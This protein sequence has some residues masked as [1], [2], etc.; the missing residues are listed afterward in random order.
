MTP[1]TLPEIITDLPAAIYHADRDTISKHGLDKIAEAPAKY[2]YLLDNP[3]DPTPAMRWGTLVHL[4]VLE[5]DRFAEE[6]VV[7]PA[8]APERPAARSLNAKKPRP[9]V[10]E[11][12]EW[13]SRFDQE[14]AEKQIVSAVEIEEI[15]AI[16]NAV[17]AHP[18]ARK[19]ITAARSV[20][21]A[22]IYWEA[23]N[24]IKCRCRPDLL[25][26][27]GIA[28]DLK[29]TEDASPRAFAKSVANFRY[30]VQ[31]AFYLDGLAAVAGPSE[32]KGFAFVCVEKK[33]PYLV[34][35]YEASPEMIAAGRRLYERDLETFAECLRTDTWPGYSEKVERLDL[36]AWA[37][38]I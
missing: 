17:H 14:N 10:L 12:A 4:A 18:A 2:R 23:F 20:I 7:I 32:A 19:A 27:A 34:A 30:H 35:V 33:P 13:W 21:E 38:T 31:A 37:M 26:P 28:V 29:T 24:G 11:A 6:I 3:E 25:H 1:G 5:P 8:D 15:S 16:K 36:P 9:E 22:S